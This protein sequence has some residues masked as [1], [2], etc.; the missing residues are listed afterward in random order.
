MNVKRHNNIK[1]YKGN[2]PQNVNR[3]KRISGDNLQDLDENRQKKN[4]PSKAI[5]VEYL[6]SEKVIT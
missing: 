1:I 2:T 6:L 3:I 5:D 4:Y